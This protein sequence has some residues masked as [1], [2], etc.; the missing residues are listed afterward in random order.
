MSHRIPAWKQLHLHI[1]TSS[2]EKKRKSNSSPWETCGV[3]LNLWSH[4]ECFE[5]C[6]L[7]YGTKWWVLHKKLLI[8]LYYKSEIIS[9]RCSFM[10]FPTNEFFSCCVEQLWAIITQANWNIK[11]SSQSSSRNKNITLTQKGTSVTTSWKAKIFS[12][13]LGFSQ[14][15]KLL[16]LLFC[17]LVL[18]IVSVFVS[19]KP[20]RHADKELGHFSTT[21]STNF[22]KPEFLS[23]G[24]QKTSQVCKNLQ[25]TC[26][27]LSTFVCKPLPSKLCAATR[28]TPEC[29][30]KAAVTFSSRGRN[31]C[32]PWGDK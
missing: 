26:S 14:K 16:F 27:R 4:A 12:V 18:N 13:C 8:L 28:E 10:W 30:T 17:S 25:E 29:L 22:Q 20:P 31:C 24:S 1:K 2:E 9:P 5:L 19:L 32:S 11:Y 3:S 21:I 15:R 23:K 7:W 6:V